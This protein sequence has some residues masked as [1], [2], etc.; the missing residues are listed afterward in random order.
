M[1]TSSI[2]FAALF[3]GATAMSA[4]A[5]VTYTV[6]PGAAWIGYMNV[7]NLPSAGGAFQFGSTW[8]T[9]DLSAS[10]SG[11]TLALTPNTIGDPN[12][13]WYSPSGGPGAVGQKIME[14]N[15]YI[16]PADGTL[17]GQ[18]ITFTGQVVS[19][20]LTT[21]HTAIAFIKDFAPDYSS[22][23][24]TTVAL[25]PGVFSI[26]L[27][28]LNDPARHI[29][30]GFTTKGVNVWV[31]DVDPFGKVSVTAVPEPSALLLGL[32]GLGAMVRR[33]R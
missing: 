27:T 10:F 28:A 1:K 14:A 17:N 24:E 23:V 7:F 6:D 12:P 20:T 19:N 22:F 4:T 31:T 9:A 2:L 11:P 21:A 26:S 13:Y 32:L 8:G 15:F 3:S 25:T 33:R 29:Q 18:Q 16:Q 30:Y 5:A